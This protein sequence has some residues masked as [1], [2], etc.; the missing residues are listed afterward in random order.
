MPRENVALL[1]AKLGLESHSEGGYY[2]EYLRSM[3]R[4]RPP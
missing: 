1:K 4:V 2:K 3:D